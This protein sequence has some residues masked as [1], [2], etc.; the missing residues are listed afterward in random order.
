MAGRTKSKWE[1][2]YRIRHK[3]NDLMAQATKAYQHERKKSKKGRDGLRKICLTFE[4]LHFQESGERIKLC[5]MTLKCLAEGGSTRE[6]ANADRSWLTSEEE[7]VVVEFV[8]EMAAQGFPYSHKQVKE[9]VDMIAGARWGDKFPS[10]GVGANWTYWFSKHHAE[11]I[12]RGRAANPANNDLWWEILG[13][14]IVKYLIKPENTYGT[15]EVGI[16]AQGQGK[17]EYVFGPRTKGAPYQQRA[18]SWE[19]ITVIVTIC[20]DGT[21]TP[22]AALH[23]MAYT[24][25]LTLELIKTAFRKTGI[26]P[27]D[28]SVITPAMLATSK[29]TSKDA[30]L[31]ASIPSDPDSVE[32]VHIL[33]D[34]LQQLQ[35]ANVNPTAADPAPSDSSPNPSN[36]EVAEIAPAAPGPSRS[37]VTRRTT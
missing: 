34:M 33:A 3:Y 12:K 32:A 11:R 37:Q 7:N 27:F 6:Q 1:K 24:T 28:P 4:E 22:P 35:L 30:H 18:G 5:H 15:D 19:N 13:E 29:D 31:P 23:I 36:S 25:A 17:R 20:A 8:C 26:H 10:E 16:Q 2:N 21:T 14:V 9:A